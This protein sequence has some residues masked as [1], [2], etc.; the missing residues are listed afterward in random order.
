M[1]VVYVAGPYM[2]ETHDGK[3][4]FQIHTN[5]MVAREW[6]KKVFALGAFAFCPHLNCFHM[7]LDT[8]FS[9]DWWRKADLEIL[10]R[11]DAVLLIPGWENSR[12]SVMEKT[13][14]QDNSIPVFYTEN[15]LREW[16]QGETK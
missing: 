11:C 9:A 13:F 7:E 8:D 14:A 12:G 3:S 1:K 5:I 16:L 15:E 2:G 10:E 6:A 4:F